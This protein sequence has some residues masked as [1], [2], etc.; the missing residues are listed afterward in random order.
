[1]SN[2]RIEQAKG[3]PWGEFIALRLARK[4]AAAVEFFD[5]H[6]ESLVAR[7]HRRGSR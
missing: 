5:E 6:L 1:M 7:R 4:H 3:D 2:W